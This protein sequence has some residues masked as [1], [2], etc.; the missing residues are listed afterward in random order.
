MSRIRNTDQNA[1]IR[2]SFTETG[3]RKKLLFLYYLRCFENAVIREID[4]FMSQLGK[5]IPTDQLLGPGSSL[6]S[7]WVPVRWE[8]GFHPPL[9]SS[10][11]YGT[12]NAYIVPKNKLRSFL[13]V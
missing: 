13:K 9:R 5:K 12:R 7:R 4:F 6:F 3:E 8:Q 2:S 1:L 10:C 11:S